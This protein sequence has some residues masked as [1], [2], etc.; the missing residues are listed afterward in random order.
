MNT[1]ILFRL[2]VAAS[3]M[4]S[5]AL[6]GRAIAQTS[7]DTNRP[8]DNTEM[9]MMD[10]AP[11][12]MEGNMMPDSTTPDSMTQD[13]MTPEPMTPESSAAPGSSSISSL[14]ASSQSLSTL[15][16][17][18]QA[19]SLVETLNG[20]GPY[21]VFAPTNEAFAELPTGALDFLLRPENKD[22]LQQVLRY[23][24]VPGE[25]MAADLS[26][27]GISSLAGGIAVRVTD[28]RVIINN[29]SVV[30]PDI[31]ASNGVV[32]VVNRVLIP[33][34]VRDQLLAQLAQLSQ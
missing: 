13:S 20:S 18:L 32:H 2:G 9:P 4:S 26:T 1:Q 31:E 15:T 3:L 25:V 33:S 30:Q 16:Q 23:H 34:A 28:D 19:A 7:V 17:A 11:E 21:T 14:A 24:V 22:L 27:G 12:T 29:G 10:S 8:E 5:F 6:G